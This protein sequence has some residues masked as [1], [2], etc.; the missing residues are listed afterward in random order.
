MKVVR[1]SFTA[2]STFEGVAGSKK[3]AK[4]NAFDN[5]LVLLLSLQ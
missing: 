1:G 5:F 4:I 3:K 2:L